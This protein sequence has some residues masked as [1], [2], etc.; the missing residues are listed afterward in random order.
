MS[1]SIISSLA[2]RS[3]NLLAQSP[4]NFQS[5]IRSN[6]IIL[7]S[8]FSTTNPTYWKSIKPKNKPN[9][10]KL[11]THQ[12][13]SKRFFVTGN[14]Q[15]KRC[16]AGKQHLM[17]GTSHTNKRK[18]K[19][20]IIVNKSHNNRLRKL[21][22]YSYKRAGF[23]RVNERDTVWWSSGKLQKTGLALLNAINRAELLKKKINCN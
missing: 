6:Q 14:G 23:R 4:R 17:T 10:Y 8:F 20:M 19:P 15:F 5:Y 12:G 18:L 16:Q 9:R 3:K 21:L 13:A 1:F 2:L 7:K 22:P 11:K